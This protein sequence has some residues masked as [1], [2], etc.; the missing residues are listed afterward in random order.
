M[1][2]REPRRLLDQ[3]QLYG[4]G[5]SL[6]TATRPQLAVEV[7]D[8]RLDRTQRDEE[9]TCDLPVGLASGDK[10]EHLQ[11]ALAQRLRELFADI[12]GGTFLCENGQQLREVARRDPDCGVGVAPVACFDGRGQEVG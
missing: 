8:V 4:A 7:V 9:A 10:P 12:W 2:A 11:L 5:Y 3:I 1:P 6:G